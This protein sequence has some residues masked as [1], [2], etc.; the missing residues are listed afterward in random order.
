MARDVVR[1]RVGL[2][3]ALGDRRVLVEPINQVLGDRP[4]LDHAAEA[5]VRVGQ[6]RLHHAAELGRNPL[7]LQPPSNNA[8]ALGV[9][10]ETV[11]GT[12][13]AVHTDKRHPAD[14]ADTLAHYDAGYG[15]YL[16][17]GWLYGFWWGGVWGSIGLLLG[18]MSAMYIGRRFGRPLVIRM[19]G[20]GTLAR[21]ERLTHSDSSLVW[22]GIL[23]SPI[24]DAPF[25]LAGLASVRF[26]KILLLAIIT[27]VRRRRPWRRRNAPDM[28][29]ATVNYCATGNSVRNTGALS[30]T[31]FRAF[32]ADDCASDSIVT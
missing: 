27:R 29:A 24:G 12:R 13:F 11:P 10:A 26:R 9:P 8:Q 7:L 18:G 2:A 21:W 16:A 25:M 22:F 23:L 6:V 5:V 28:V 15:V 19:I 31:D 14:F 32:T 17:A 30:R 4:R 3:V 20:A 1:E